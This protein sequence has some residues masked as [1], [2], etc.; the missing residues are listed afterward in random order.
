MVLIILVFA[1]ISY[2]IIEKSGIISVR[3]TEF[4]A[5]LSISSVRARQN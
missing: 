4:S 1:K 3:L 2:L 5:F